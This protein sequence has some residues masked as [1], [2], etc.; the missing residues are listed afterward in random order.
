[1]GTQ[2]PKKG[3]SAPTFRHMTIVAN[4]RPSQ[5]LLSSCSY[6]LQET[7]TP[8]VLQIRPRVRALG[9]IKTPVRSEERLY[10]VKNISCRRK[11]DKHLRQLSLPS[12]Q[13]SLLYPEWDENEYRLKCGGGLRL[14][15]KGRCGSFHLWINVWVAGKAVRSLLNTCHI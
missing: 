4:G 1:M 11:A 8:E 15:S 7:A 2:L 6:C 13:F 14:G 5:Q 3:T 9:R 12:D 10:Q